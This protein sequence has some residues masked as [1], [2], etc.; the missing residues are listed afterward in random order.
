MRWR[1]HRVECR[2]RLLDRRSVAFEASNLD[3]REPFPEAF[4][5]NRTEHRSTERIFDGRVAFVFSSGNYSYLIVY[6]PETQTSP[7]SCPPPVNV[8]CSADTSSGIVPELRQLAR[9]I[10]AVRM[11]RNS[12]LEADFH[13]RKQILRRY[14]KTHWRTLFADD[15]VRTNFEASALV[16]CGAA[17]ARRRAPF[18]DDQ[19]MRLL[20]GAWL[21]AG[22]QC[23]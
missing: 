8:N 22:L 19:R 6:L 3:A 14:G 11:T 12:I 4:D 5:S 23:R 2:G 7:G 9:C 10:A 18:P 17:F 20:S 21:H 15:R 1:T 13:R 16:T